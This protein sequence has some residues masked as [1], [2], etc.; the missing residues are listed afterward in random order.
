MNHLIWEFQQLVRT[1]VKIINRTRPALKWRSRREEMERRK[2]FLGLSKALKKNI[3][4]P[5]SNSDLANVHW[6]LWY[7]RDWDLSSMF[8]FKD[9][10]KNEGLRKR[11]YLHP[12]HPLQGVVPWC[13]LFSKA[14]RKRRGVTGDKR[15]EG[16]A[17]C[18]WMNH[19][20]M[21]PGKQLPQF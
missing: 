14:G 8:I 4:P 2:G 17:T 1:A 18:V 10:K 5:V 15:S 11:L 7:A 19:R 21:A 9:R 13:W 3:W 16:R 20:K 12:D 6:E